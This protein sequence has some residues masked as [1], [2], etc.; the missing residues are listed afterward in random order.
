MKSAPILF[1]E[2]DKLLG[3]FVRGVDG[4]LGERLVG[5]YL[6]GSFALGDADV[7]SD[8][9]FIAAVAGEPTDEDVVELETLHASLSRLPTQWAR[10]LD[11][12]YIPVDRLRAKGAIPRPFVYFDNGAV[13]A[14][15]DPHD[16][17]QILRWVF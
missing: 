7:H 4:A 1:P 16:D 13:T 12:S 5:L 9:D 3:R 2:L 11:G 14:R 8:V 10:H 17:T 15:R 6:V